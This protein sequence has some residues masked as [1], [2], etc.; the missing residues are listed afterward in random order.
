M[1]FGFRWG[2]LD[3]GALDLMERYSDIIIQ[4]TPVGAFPNT[5]DDPFE[6][7]HFNGHETVMDM[8]YNPPRT[9]FLRRAE[10]A[11]AKA[12]N[13]F[14]MLIRQAKYQYQYFFERDF[15]DELIPRLAGALGQ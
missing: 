7:Y 8:I 4:T 12:L 3:S 5:D 9:A 6:L 1:T 11:G 15:P 10:K 14:D 2:G 13:G